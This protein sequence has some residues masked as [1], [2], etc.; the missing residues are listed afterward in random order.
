MRTT[1]DDE[2]AGL[3]ID[4]EEEDDNCEEARKEL[5]GV[6]DKERG[7]QINKDD[8]R[9]AGK[10]LKDSRREGRSD[11]DRDRDRESSPCYSRG[12]FCLCH[13]EGS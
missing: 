9:A 12:P 3:E 7:R 8:A 13:T 2:S 6:K 4:D 5:K 1:K 11:R 10:D